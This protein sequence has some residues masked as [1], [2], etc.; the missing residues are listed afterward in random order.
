[1]ILYVISSFIFFLQVHQLESARI[2][3]E[4]LLLQQ[5]QLSSY[6]DTAQ[7]LFFNQPTLVS[8]SMNR[9]L[10]VMSS[11]TTHETSPSFI[12]MSSE[13]ISLPMSPI[14]TCDICLFESRT[15]CELLLHKMTNH[16]TSHMMQ[17]PSCPYALERKKSSVMLSHLRRHT[18][19]KPYMCHVCKKTFPR[20][21]DLDMHLNSHTGEKPFKCDFCSYRAYKRSCVR[22]HCYRK[23]GVMGSQ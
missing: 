8:S 7:T 14:N 9:D 17:C 16:S 23:H 5:L 21:C 18:G 15:T 11:N 6:T 22:Q 1:M 4:A 12:E 10:S 20:K 19:E 13:D 2:E 3:H